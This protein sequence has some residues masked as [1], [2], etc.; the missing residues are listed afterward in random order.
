MRGG[1]RPAV[2]LQGQLL[3]LPRDEGRAPG[4]P[5]PA[6]GQAGEAHGARAGMGAHVALG[7][8]CQVQGASVGL[9]QDDERGREAEGRETRNF[10]SERS[11]PGR[12]GHRGAGRDEG[13]RR[14][15]ALR[16]PGL[17]APAC[18]HRGSHRSQRNGQD[19][20]FPHDHGT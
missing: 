1:P 12:C 10:H 11:A 5:R 20:S 6:A 18:G 13:F 15:G 16:K 9:R 4:S 8:P 14:P 2:P 19:H 3:H 17:L 7:P